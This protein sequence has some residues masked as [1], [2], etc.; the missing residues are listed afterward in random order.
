MRREGNKK[1]KQE[2]RGNSITSP[3]WLHMQGRLITWPW[4]QSTAASRKIKSEMKSWAPS[5]QSERSVPWI[6]CELR[7]SGDKGAGVLSQYADKHS[8]SAD[9]V[10]D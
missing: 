6:G 2:R 4:P 1:K 7:A 8:S 9:D 5:I 10:A 3:Q